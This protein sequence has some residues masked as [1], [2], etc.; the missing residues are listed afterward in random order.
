MKLRGPEA[1]KADVQRRDSEYVGKDFEYGVGR[2]TIVV[3][4]MLRVGE[5]EWML[6]I[7]S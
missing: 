3:K 6:E 2:K 5:T 1:T 7:R 4:D